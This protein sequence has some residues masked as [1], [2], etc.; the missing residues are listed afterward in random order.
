MHSKPKL[1]NAAKFGFQTPSIHSQHSP[2]R[3]HSRTASNKPLRVMKFGGTSVADASC[4]E[5]VAEIISSAARSSHLVVVVSAMSG[6]TNKLMEAAAFAQ[7]GRSGQVAAI[8]RQLQARHEQVAAALIP[9]SAERSRIGRKMTRLF[10]EGEYLCQ[11]ALLAQQVTPQTR[12]SVASLG[13]RLSAPLVAA[14][15]AQRALKSEAIAATDLIFT[16]ANFGSADPHMDVTRAQCESQLRPLLRQGIIPVVTGFI[17][18]TAQGVLTTLGRGGSDYSATILGAALGADEVIIWTDVDGVMTADPRLVPNARTIP[19]ISYREAADLAYFGAK[20]LHPKTLRP[21]MESDTPVWIRNSFA[22]GQPGTRISPAG[23]ASRGD[24]KA[25]TAISE[26]RWIGIAGAGIAE[27]PDLI[28]RATAALSAIRAD[29][30]LTSLCQSREEISIAVNSAEAAH[31]A[32]ALRQEF[33]TELAQATL[34]RV[35]FRG[36]VAL[37]TLVGQA[38]HNVPEIRDRALAALAQAQ[39][40]VSAFGD[41]SAHGNVSLAVAHE[42]V[43][44]A[45]VVLHQ[46]FRLADFDSRPLPIEIPSS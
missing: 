38:L 4:I 27:V 46:E 8:F 12:D 26:I 32:A 30:W 2:G 19:E 6:V 34:D 40:E 37:V 23:L 11:A 17:G 3:V 16:D 29:V 21:V 10:H 13:E 39:I 7:D 9:S 20:V 42:T 28:G 18:A 44:Q 31:S 22:P 5:R 14:A 45:L 43:K 1:Q 25:V 41:G 33:A 35:E 36:S 15:L 24:V